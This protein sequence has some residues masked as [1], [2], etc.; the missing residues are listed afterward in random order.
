MKPDEIFLEDLLKFVGLLVFRY[1]EY[2]DRVG[3]CAVASFVMW[4]VL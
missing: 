1:V 3:W 2:F 4:I